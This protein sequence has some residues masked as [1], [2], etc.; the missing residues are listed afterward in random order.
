LVKVLPE[1]WLM[2]TALVQILGV[3]MWE[4]LWKNIIVVDGCCGW[5]VEASLD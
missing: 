4:K 2:M 3:A 5:L 1:G